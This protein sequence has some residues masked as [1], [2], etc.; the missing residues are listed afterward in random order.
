MEDLFRFLERYWWLLFILLPWIGSVVGDVFTKAAQKAAAEE[1]ARR[2]QAQGG[3]Q[4]Q[5]TGTQL[6]A[7][8][9][10]TAEEVAAEIRRMMGMEVVEEQRSSRPVVLEEEWEEPEWEEPRPEPEPGPK[11]VPAQSL[12]ERLAARETREIS[13]V[14]GRH[15]ETALTRTSE[16]RGGR[17]D[18]RRMARALPGLRGM[19]AGGLVDLDDPAK[20]FVLMEVFGPPKALRDES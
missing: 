15:P 13:R 20:A 4:P 6:P 12:R 10:P 11:P 1:R 19:R 3:S 2:R 14:E 8:Q 7:K 9:R 5:E 16:V 17:Y 18:R